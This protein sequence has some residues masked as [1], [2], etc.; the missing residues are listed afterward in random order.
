MVALCQHWR[1]TTVAKCSIFS[2]TSFDADIDSFRH[3][4]F[5]ISD[6]ANDTS[7]ILSV[8]LTT[9]DVTKRPSQFNDPACVLEAGEHP[10]VEHPTCVCYAGA[11]VCSLYAFESRLTNGRFRLRNDPA[12]PL[13]LA[14][15]QTSSAESKFMEIGRFEILN[16]QCLA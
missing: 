2:G 4:W 7:Q 14:K 11:C 3:P 8:N 6:P 13:L 12:S 16:D 1:T 5:V 10:F 9:Y 15:M